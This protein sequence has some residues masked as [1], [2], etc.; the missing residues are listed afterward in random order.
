MA[1]LRFKICQK[2]PENAL[3][4]AVW[5]PR[6]C[7]KGSICIGTSLNKHLS[8]SFSVLCTRL[9]ASTTSFGPKIPQN[10][11]E[12]HPFCMPFQITPSRAV[13]YSHELHFGT[14]V[15]INNDGWDHFEAFS[16]L[17]SPFNAPFR[18]RRV[19][20]S[21]HGARARVGSRGSSVGPKMVQNYFFQICCQITW[22]AQTSVFSPF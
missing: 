8:S 7:V 20:F 11:P 15:V 22:G 19:V 17:S 13:F 14:L 18:H 12:K 5:V 6:I 9:G 1:D 4:W 3:F 2:W 10:Q 16:T 21:A